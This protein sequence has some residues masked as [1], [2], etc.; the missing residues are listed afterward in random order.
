MWRSDISQFVSRSSYKTLE[1]MIAQGRERE[2][3]IETEKKKKLAKVQIFMGLEPLWQ[4]QQD[5]RG[6]V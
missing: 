3:D 6:C 5:S 2:I 1:D 4:V